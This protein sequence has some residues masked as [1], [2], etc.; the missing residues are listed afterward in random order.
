[1]PIYIGNTKYNLSGIDK[2]YFGNVLVWQKPDDNSNDS[3][4]S[5]E[6]NEDQ[7]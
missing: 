5:P 2:A 4:A 3:A 7:N 6:D 1:M